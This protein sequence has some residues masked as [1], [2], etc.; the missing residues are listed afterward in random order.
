M[1]IILISDITNTIF[2]ISIIMIIIIIIVERMISSAYVKTLA[3]SDC[4][5]RSGCSS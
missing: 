4:F 2:S 5:E 1:V 3:G